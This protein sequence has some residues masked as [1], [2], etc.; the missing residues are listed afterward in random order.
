MIL[1]KFGSWLGGLEMPSALALPLK[2][3]EVTKLPENFAAII[4]QGNIGTSDNFQVSI[5]FS[6]ALRCLKASTG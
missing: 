1:M 5:V 2:E 4:A 6:L 3:V